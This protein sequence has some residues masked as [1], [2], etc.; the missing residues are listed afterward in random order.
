MGITTPGR[1]RPTTRRRRVRRASLLALS[2]VFVL[3]G[4]SCTLK[5]DQQYRVTGGTKL[6]A[7]IFSNPSWMIAGVAYRDV[8]H[9]NIVCAADLVHERARFDGWGAAEFNDGI[10]DYADFWP[11]VDYVARR[12]YDSFLEQGNACLVLTKSLS[13]NLDWETRLLSHVDCRP[14]TLG[15]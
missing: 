11:A 12:G 15:L 7:T 14:G 10:R 4:W 6:Y 13:G 5:Q 2:A 9:W 1:T 8:C 3:T